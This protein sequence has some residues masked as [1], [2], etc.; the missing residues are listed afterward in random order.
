M[1]D[2]K[3]TET[4]RDAHVAFRTSI[5]CSNTGGTV[6]RMDDV[7]ITLHQAFPSPFPDDETSLSG[8]K[9]RAH[10]LMLAAGRAGVPAGLRPA[11]G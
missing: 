1:L 11:V 6:Y 10:E 7:P 5:C 4:A 3:E 8:I 9:K 2:P